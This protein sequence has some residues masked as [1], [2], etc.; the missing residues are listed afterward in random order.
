MAWMTETL[1]D[2]LRMQVEA[3]SIL[4]DSET[5]HQR[6]VVFE[7]PTLGRVMMLDDIVQTTE[8]DEFIY[9][10]MLAHV[11]VLAHG[12]AR[13]VLIIGGG[14]GGM[15]EE[16][17]KHPGV[18]RATMVE[19]D[20]DVIDICREHLPSICGDAFDDPRTDLVINDGV[21]FVEADG[22]KYD[23]M[24]VD[25]TDPVGPGEALFGADFYAGC[26]SRLKPGGVLVTQN[27]VPFFQDIE[28]TTTAH[29]LRGLFDDVSCYLASVPL[30]VGGVMA[31]GWAS[32][33]AA[34]RTVP[35]ETLQA[36]FED[37]GI[38]TRYY[39]PAVH[40]GAF[41]VPPYIAEMLGRSV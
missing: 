28:L 38:D 1:H 27:G 15:L 11:P 13:D 22:D 10:E 8:V 6:L 2:G 36:R 4:F 34:L 12:A 17:L 35:V 21:A 5:E 29:F 24:I 16:V 3:T 19:I 20:R 40:H 25:S 18:E 30:Y 37:A 32:D 23:V 14:D 9:H 7:N 41:A 39:A 33:N 31:F 26:K